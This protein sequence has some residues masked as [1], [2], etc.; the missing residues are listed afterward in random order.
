MQV[1]CVIKPLRNITTMLPPH[2]AFIVTERIP[3]EH[4]TASPSVALTTS[5]RH[6]GGLQRWDHVLCIV[7]KARRFPYPLLPPSLFK[8]IIPTNRWVEEKTPACCTA[9]T[10]SVA[11]IPPSLTFSPSLPPLSFSTRFWPTWDME[12]V[13]L[14]VRQFFLWVD[15]K[16]LVG[17]TR[18]WEFCLTSNSNVISAAVNGMINTVLSSKESIPVK[19]KFKRTLSMD[20]RTVWLSRTQ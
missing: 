3:R 15:S 10:L 20:C 13:S 12:G 6:R 18:P 14:D 1:E 4:S 17:W 2:I 19:E 7:M 16:F 11:P 8:W 5:C 9:V